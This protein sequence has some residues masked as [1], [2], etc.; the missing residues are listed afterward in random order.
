MM[1]S[2]TVTKSDISKHLDRLS[3][4]AP[5]SSTTPILE[6]VMVKVE[7][8]TIKLTAGNDETKV[9]INAGRVFDSS[10]DV[11]FCTNA[12]QLSDSISKMPESP[13]RFIYN[14]KE[15]SIVI[16]YG[17]GEVKF[18]TFDPDL[19]PSINIIEGETITLNEE[20]IKRIGKAFNFTSNDEL[21]PIT[22][23]VLI[24]TKN[25][26]IAST[27]QI[28]V[29]MSKGLEISE[30]IEP[31]VVTR[32]VNMAIKGFS[33]LKVKAN[34]STA[35]FFNDDVFISTTL[36]EGHFPNYLAVIPS[37]KDK[38]VFNRQDI[39]NT[40]DRA[41]LCASDFMPVIRFQFGDKSFVESEDLMNGKKFKEDINCT[42]EVDTFIKLTGDLLKSSL[43]NVG[44]K[45][46]AI[47]CVNTNTPVLISGY[48][49][50][51]EIVD[52]EEVILV[53]PR[54]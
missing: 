54:A 48:I 4:I 13:I 19:Y 32:G 29:Y 11:S 20:N 22:M 17:L 15:N 24:D 44:Y 35:N 3:R 36:M 5:A 31:F 52:N 6:S 7:E 2:F 25:G 42:S 37:L 50:D 43:V 14:E 12:K 53:A 34:D 46:V 30:S 41:M 45:D 23:G 18:A 51:K 40:I 28:S 16:D 26:N 38:V 33:E 10:G 47:R 1:K 27:N 21:R 8:D 49:S 39:L 9:V